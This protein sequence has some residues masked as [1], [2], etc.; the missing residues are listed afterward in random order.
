MVSIGAGGVYCC[1]VGVYVMFCSGV[2][3]CAD[4]CCVSSVVECVFLGL[5][6]GLCIVRL[7]S[8]CDGCCALCLMCDACNLRCS[9]SS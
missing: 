7:C 3:D 1:E 8:G 2:D 6:V 9:W 5:R 4:V